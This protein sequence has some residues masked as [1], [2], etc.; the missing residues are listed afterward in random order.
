M[1]IKSNSEIQG[2]QHPA[3]DVYEEKDEKYLDTDN[4]QILGG[5][6][7]E[8]TPADA[9][10]DALTE[11]VKHGETLDPEMRAKIAAYYGRKAE[12]DHLAP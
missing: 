1:A 2:V 9:T 7:V 8:I 5:D 11:K 3:G 12:E 4:V 10:I 6:D